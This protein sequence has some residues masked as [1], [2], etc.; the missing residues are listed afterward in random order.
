VLLHIGAR[1][2]VYEYLPPWDGLCHS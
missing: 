2:C 1:A